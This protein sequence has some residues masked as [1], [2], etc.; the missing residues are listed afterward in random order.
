MTTSPDTTSLKDSSR[1]EKPHACDRCT[2]PEA[3]KLYL[4]GTGSNWEHAG[5]NHHDI[6]R[7]VIAGDT[8]ARLRVDNTQDIFAQVSY[9]D[10]KGELVNGEYDVG[11][12]ARQPIDWKLVG[13][14]TPLQKLTEE[15][16]SLLEV[17]TGQV[18]TWQ[19]IELLVSPQDIQRLYQMGGTAEV[20]TII[21]KAEQSESDPGQ[22]EVSIRKII[23][24]ERFTLR[25]ADIFVLAKD[26]GGT[27]PPV[28]APP[29]AAPPPPDHHQDQQ[30]ALWR[31]KKVYRGQ[32][33]ITDAFNKHSGGKAIGWPAIRL[34][35]EQGLNI[36]YEKH[37]N[38]EIPTLDHYDLI[39]FLGHT[40]P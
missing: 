1:G 33:E 27:T 9:R 6:I 30:P 12:P 40:L 19:S 5:L 22:P 20:R 36:V 21:G 38:K 2:T 17:P 39:D 34:K 25:L 11:E 14:F 3:E 28:A 37:G 31:G 26:V 35:R 15:D 29:T 10:S 8:V 23:E 24:E 18:P 4:D 7:A 16:K 13:I 32:K